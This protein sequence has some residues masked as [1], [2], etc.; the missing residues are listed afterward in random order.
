MTRC[1]R[2]L[3]PLCLAP[4]AQVAECEWMFVKGCGADFGLPLICNPLARHITFTTPV[5]LHPCG[6]CT[7]A[8]PA[9]R[10]WRSAAD[11]THAPQYRECRKQ[12][13]R[14]SWAIVCQ[15]RAGFCAA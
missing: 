7:P 8:W 15:M 6:R 3:R 10:G 11:Q 13:C 4:C 14:C 5:R 12:A 1:S 2:A 9:S